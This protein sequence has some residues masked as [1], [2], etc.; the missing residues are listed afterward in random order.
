MTYAQLVAGEDLR[1]RINSIKQM[2]EKVKIQGA[3]WLVDE[4]VSRDIVKCLDYSNVK[5]LAQ[6]MDT[7][8]KQRVKELQKEFD[9]L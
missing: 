3:D 9:E 1:D 7:T 8:L 6:W 2:V 5:Q 4:Y